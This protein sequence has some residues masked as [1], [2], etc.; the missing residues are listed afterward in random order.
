MLLRADRRFRKGDMCE[1]S[2]VV[3]GRDFMTAM[4][5]VVYSIQLR[6]D[7]YVGIRFLPSTP[8]LAKLQS[9]IR[10]YVSKAVAA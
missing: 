5:E 8:D 10:Q 2:F 1:V 3:S 4:G 7:L 6:D 9:E